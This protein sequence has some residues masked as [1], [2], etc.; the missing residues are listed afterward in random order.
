M[1]SF[2][3][4]F[5][6][7]FCN[8]FYGSVFRNFWNMSSPFMCCGFTPSFM[9]PS[10]NFNL[11]VPYN[12]STFSIAP[13]Q[14][15]AMPTSSISWADCNY[16]TPY[17]TSYIGGD[18]FTRT[19]EEDGDIKT[20]E[21]EEVVEAQR[22][23]T[24]DAKTLTQKWNKKLP[25]ASNITEEF[26]QKV[27]DISKEIGCSHDDLMAVMNLETG[28]T[29]SPSIQ[30]RGGHNYWGLIQFGESAAQDVG[31]TL[32]E[33]KAMSA[34]EQLDYVK[35]YLIKQKQNR[36]ITGEVDTKTLYC[37]IF[38]PAAAK[39][40]DSYII[41]KKGSSE[42]GGRYTANR[43]LDRDASGTITRGELDNALNSFRA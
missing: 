33:L 38:Y 23:V 42:S 27:I 25:K 15:F 29:F 21:K 41:A 6:Q 11:F 10:Y 13:I 1:S 39:A 8:G 16:A 32:N 40:D 3:N 24:P 28:G 31:K 18:T 5:S 4:S 37:L 35:K 22:E 14:N 2:A 30:N 36:K 9:V 34:I 26:C 12:Q 17:F 20:D 19:K 7:G 43:G